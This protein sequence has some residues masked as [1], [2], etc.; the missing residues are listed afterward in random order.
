MTSEARMAAILALFAWAEKEWGWGSKEYDDVVAAVDV[1]LDAAALTSA[2]EG[3]QSP[4]E[5]DDARS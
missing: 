1:V 4:Q 5:A 2:L 3:S